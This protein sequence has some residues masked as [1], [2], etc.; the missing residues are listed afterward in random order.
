M[1]LTLKISTK[2]LELRSFFF[3]ANELG[4]SPPHTAHLRCNFEHDHMTRKC[5]KHENDAGVKC[6]E[7][8][9]IRRAFL[10][11]IVDDGSSNA[12]NG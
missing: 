12:T 9:P 2:K 1:P 5:N 7:E 10:E 6:R 8:G 3:R 11:K 4:I